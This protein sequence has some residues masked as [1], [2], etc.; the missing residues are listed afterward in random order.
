MSG[1][2]YTASI[3]SFYTKLNIQNS[4][5]KAKHTRLNLNMLMI[6]RTYKTL[7]TDHAIL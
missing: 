1:L 4:I 2:L 6:I 3:Y 7:S 5:Y